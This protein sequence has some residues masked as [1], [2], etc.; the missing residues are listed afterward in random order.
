MHEH[1]KGVPVPWFPLGPPGFLF[2]GNI[3]STVL[4][5]CVSPSPPEPPRGTCSNWRCPKEGFPLAGL[6]TPSSKNTFREERGARE[7]HGQAPSSLS[8]AG[9][10]PL[11][12]EQCGTGG[13][14]RAVS[15]S[16]SRER[17]PKGQIIG[18][19]QSLQLSSAETFIVETF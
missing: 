12:V 13:R 11:D 4:H 10:Q 17:F 2:Q 3:C 15:R 9:L 6:G 8:A 19:M 14:I 1:P 16:F 18:V 5:G 7:G